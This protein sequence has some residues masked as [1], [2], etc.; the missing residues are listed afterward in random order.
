M[1]SLFRKVA[2]V[3]GLLVVVAGPLVGPRPFVAAQDDGDGT[4]AAGGRAGRTPVPVVYVDAEG[5]EL[6][7]LA[8]GRVTDPFERFDPDAAPAEGQRY[9][10]VALTV[11]NT[12]EEPLEFDPFALFLRDANGFLYRQQII[13]RRGGGREDGTPT[14]EE[15]AEEPIAGGEI[16]PGEQRTGIAGF[17][18][19]ADAALATLVFAPAGDRLLIVGELRARR[20]RDRDGTPT[21]E[22]EA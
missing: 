11:E 4:P 6:G 17:A 2:L 8:L 22:A 14:A 5:E 21:A 15:A 12:G 10:L 18:L 20:R 19:P 1:G 9:V 16:P 3:V 13:P 7:R